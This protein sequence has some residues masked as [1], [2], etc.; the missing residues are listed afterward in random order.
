MLLAG[1]IQPVVLHRKL[2]FQPLYMMLPFAQ[3]V[4]RTW[5][6][7]KAG[8]AGLLGQA[9]DCHKEVRLAWERLSATNPCV[10]RHGATDRA[11]HDALRMIL[12]EQ[13]DERE[14]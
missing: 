3:N 8:N 7:D 2:Q 1:R 5:Y 12:S 6:E 13:R 9:A 10:C 14:Y 11:E 4:S